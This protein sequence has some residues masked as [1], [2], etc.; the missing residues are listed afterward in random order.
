MWAGIGLTLSLF[1]AAFAGW[2]SLRGS[3]NFYSADVYGMTAAVHRRYAG[4]SLLFAAVFLAAIFVHTVPAVP[5]LAA[6]AVI[7]IFYFSSF[8]RGY[9]DEE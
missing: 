5:L 9:S 8:V 6:W 3:G 4:V 2:R 1:T 7:V